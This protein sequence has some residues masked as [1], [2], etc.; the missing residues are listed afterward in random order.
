MENYLEVPAKKGIFDIITER[1]EIIT[2]VDV[3]FIDDPNV[4]PLI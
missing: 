4:P 2:T 1:N 3:P